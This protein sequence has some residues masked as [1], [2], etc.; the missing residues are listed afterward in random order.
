ML[1]FLE[2]RFRP[3]ESLGGILWSGWECCLYCMGRGGC[4]IEVKAWSE[5]S[6]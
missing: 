1:V 4:W 3:R 5:E 6:R 2:A